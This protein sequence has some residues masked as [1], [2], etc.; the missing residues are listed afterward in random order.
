[1]SSQPSTVASAGVQVPVCQ[2]RPK[3]LLTGLLAESTR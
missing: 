3:P 2:Q 1:M